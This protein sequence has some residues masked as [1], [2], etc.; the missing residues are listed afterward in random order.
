MT[1]V[2]LVGGQVRLGVGGE[3]GH[4]IASCTGIRED[5]IFVRTCQKHQQLHQHTLVENLQSMEET[6][7]CLLPEKE[8]Q[9]GVFMLW[10]IKPEV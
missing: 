4:T 9:N 1:M 8:I 5:V 2:V 10:G 3:M 7:I 6:C